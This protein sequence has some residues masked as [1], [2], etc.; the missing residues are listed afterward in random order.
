MLDAFEMGLLFAFIVIYL[1][2]CTSMAQ[3]HLFEANFF[4]LRCNCYF[5]YTKFSITKSV[6]EKELG[7]FGIR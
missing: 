6:I 1:H 4:C 5:L 7:L 2:Q 3:Q